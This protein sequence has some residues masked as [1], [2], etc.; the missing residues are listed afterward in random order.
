MESHDLRIFKQVAD[1]QSVSKAAEKLGYVQ[2]NVSQRIKSLEDELGVRL[3][4]RNNRGVTLTEQGI[5]L[6]DYANRVIQ[7]LDEAVTLLHPAQ[8]KDCLTIGAS[9]TVS[10]VKIP[11]LFASFLGG[12]GH[13]DVKLKTKDK[14][15]LLTMLSYGE[16]DGAFVQGTYNTAQ[17]DTVYRY[18]EEMIL[19][20]SDSVTAVQNHAP[21][22]I[23]NGD[24]NC[25]YRQQT[26]DYAKTHY[27]EH[28]IVM[29]F[30]SL[31][32]ILQAVHDGLGM[33]VVPAAVVH[34]RNNISMMQR[35][36]LSTRIPIDFI[37]K[38]KKKQ[39]SG[40]Q[41]FIRFLQNQ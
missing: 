34:S 31:E 21:V 29:E 10:A 27:L 2:P 12:A 3:F 6:L 1:L 18:W 17:F 23:V 40:L 36:P 4:V 37:I 35:H 16:L 11:Q 25:I 15:H 24:K 5:T 33:S 30:D 38:H 14:Q 26:L 7:L 19:I 13:M 28:P 22:L 9:Q 20:S 32:A 41:K 39:P 8:S